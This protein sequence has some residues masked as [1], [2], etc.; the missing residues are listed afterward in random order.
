M[1]I[2]TEIPGQSH[3]LTGVD[4]R[5][6]VL[7]AVSILALVLSSKGFLLPLTKMAAV[8]VLLRQIKVPWKTIFLRYSEP[9]FVA[10][11]LIL[12]KFLFQGWE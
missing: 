12:I 4:G 2:P 9:L 1:E 3:V 5:L 7:V 10:L 8:L 11:I 6:K